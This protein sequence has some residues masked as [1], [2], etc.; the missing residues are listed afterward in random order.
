MGST[1]ADALKRLQA[2]PEYKT[3]FAAAFD[4]GLTAPNLGKALA[5]FERVLLR[6]DSSTDRFR[7]N[8]KHGGMS[9]AERHG[10][11]HPEWE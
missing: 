7:A 6:G 10:A 11:A 9:P 4:D 8:G 2:I 5:S 3:R 1:V